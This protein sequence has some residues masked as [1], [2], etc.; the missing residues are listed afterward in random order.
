MTSYLKRRYPKR[1]K[2]FPGPQNLS[3]TRRFFAKT[4]ILIGVH[5]GAFYN[6]HFA[7]NTAT[8]VEYIGANF[9]GRLPLTIG[10]TMIWTLTQNT[11]QT[12]YR[13][14]E[15]PL[16]KELDIQ[17]NITKLETLLNRIEGDL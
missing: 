13:V 3:E 16:N 11:G 9:D 5:G 2:Q 1:F 15:K 10:H 12:F 6:L 4:R 8:I 14:Y 7:P 17:I